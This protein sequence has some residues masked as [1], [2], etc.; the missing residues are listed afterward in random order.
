MSAPAKIRRSWRYYFVRT[1]ATIFLLAGAIS[2]KTLVG[3]IPFDGAWRLI[4]GVVDVLTI[5]AA[6]WT[7][8]IIWGY[9]WP[10]RGR[11]IGD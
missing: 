5:G 1:W 3:Q 4:P 6:I 7:T 2:L 11:D 8:S 10:S 9:Q